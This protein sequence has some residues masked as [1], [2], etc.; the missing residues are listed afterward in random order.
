MKNIDFYDFD[1]TLIDT[2]ADIRAS[3]RQ[4]L[5]ELGLPLEH[6][7]FF[8]K[9]GPPLEA[10]LRLLL[11][12]ASPETIDLASARFRAL[13]DTGG[14]PLT[15]PFPG[16]PEALARRRTEGAR[17]FI[18]TNKR[19]A[20]TLALLDKFHLRGFFEGVLASDS[21]GRS[22]TKTELLLL[23]FERYNLNRTAARM[24]GD[25]TNDIAAGRAA[26][27]PTLGVTWGYGTAEELS[28]AGADGLIDRPDQL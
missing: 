15:A 2:A 25:M 14:Y 17:L 28:Q 20:P 18:A 24:I 11:P 8:F 9:V 19:L 27:L 4:A 5:A 22:L 16:I 13:Y 12:D 6:F 26:G 10:T 7:D 21:E 23:A 1:G 3:F